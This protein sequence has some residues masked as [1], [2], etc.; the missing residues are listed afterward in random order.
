MVDRDPLLI[1]ENEILVASQLLKTFTK[2]GKPIL[3]RIVLRKIN[4][5]IDMFI[6]HYQ[7]SKL[8]RD[9]GWCNTHEHVANKD[10]YTYDICW[11]FKVPSIFVFT[12]AVK[13]WIWDLYSL[14]IGKCLQL[15]ICLFLR[16]STNANKEDENLY[17]LSIGKSII[18][19]LAF[20][21]R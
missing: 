17:S 8:F 14:S 13:C 19:S 11:K 2:K 4:K 3:I 9:V 5:L 21:K 15:H 6:L 16:I 1:L 18:S 20:T 12:N 7:D 10:S